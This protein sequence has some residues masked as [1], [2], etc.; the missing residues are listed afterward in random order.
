MIKVYYGCDYL[1]DHKALT[2][3]IIDVDF[4][5]FDTLLEAVK[6]AIECTECLNIKE[7]LKK[8]GIPEDLLDENL[9]PEDL[10]L[11]FNNFVRYQDNNQYN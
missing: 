7:L 10:L 4:K 8:Q 3:N 1:G 2:L 5:T 11:N 9:R 6:F